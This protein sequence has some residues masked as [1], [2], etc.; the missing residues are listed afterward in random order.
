MKPGKELDELIAK[1]IFGMIECDKW[2][3]SNLG[4]AGGPVLMSNCKHD[5]ETCWP[6]QE[7][8][9]FFGMI[10]GCSKYSTD[11]TQNRILLNKMLEALPQKDIHIEHLDGVGWQVST[12]HEEDGWKGWVQGETLEHAIALAALELFKI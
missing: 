6:K 4:S 1:N 10:G 8:S 2:Q 9:S 7:I 12:C 5:H 11:L 3:S